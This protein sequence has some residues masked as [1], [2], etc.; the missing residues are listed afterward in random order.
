MVAGTEQDILLE[1]DDK[2]YVGASPVKVVPWSVY[3][4]VATIIRVGDRR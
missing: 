3:K 2:V 1:P 4:V